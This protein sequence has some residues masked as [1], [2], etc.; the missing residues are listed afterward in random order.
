M[1][2]GDTRRSVA[3][4]LLREG[5]G[6]HLNLYNF[7]SSLSTFHVPRRIRIVT[8]PEA[9]AFPPSLRVVNS[10]LHRPRVV[11]HGV[12]NTDRHELAGFRNQRQDSVGVNGSC[13]RDIFS[14]AQNTVSVNKE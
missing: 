10:P 12:R 4:R 9:A 14:E 8:G 11:P 5:I 3:T 6:T 7:V 13:H 1:R 2:A